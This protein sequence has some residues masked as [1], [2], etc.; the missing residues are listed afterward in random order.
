MKIDRP[1]I[2]VPYEQV[3]VLCELLNITLLLLIWIYTIYSF[4]DL[5][6]EIP[7]H[8]NGAGE[9]DDFGGKAT[10]WI[11]P[12]IATFMFLLMF[13]LNRFPHLHNYMV[14]I[15]EENALKN[16]RLSTRMVRFINLYCLAL[17]AA[18]IFEIIAVAKG[19]A[20]TLFN[21]GFL[22]ITIIVPIIIIAVS[23]YYYNKINK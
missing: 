20:I 22:V 12:I 13:I 19:N 10:I 8:F 1:K 6:D 15:T 11:V 18:I 16:Y 5:P 4:S 7:T 14:N 3:D 17:F 21:T 2:K 23:F 9:A